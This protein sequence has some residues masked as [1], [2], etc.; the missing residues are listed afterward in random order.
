MGGMERR[1]LAI[2]LIALLMLG[3]G[4]TAGA[5]EEAPSVMQLRVDG[6]VDPFMSDYVKSGLEDAQGAGME[7]VLI[8]ID[9]PGGLMSSMREITQEI[10]N[11]PVPVITYVYP[12][13]ARA[14]S[15]GTFILM[16]APV[17]AMA[18]G[19][20][21]GAAH[22][23]GLAG[24]VESEK[25]TNDAA[26]YLQSIAEAQGRNEEWA[27]E[28]VRE[29]SSIT[30]E[31]ALDTNVIDIIAQDI[32][33]LL[34]QTDGM[35]VTVGGG[36]TVTLDTSGAT[37]V[38]NDM[39]GFIGFLHALLNPDVAFI[40]F[41]LGL[42]LIIL[43]IFA[44]G[45]LAGTLGGIMFILA[46]V[47]FGMLPVQLIGIA[48]LIVSV[49][50]FIVELKHPGVGGPAIVGAIA[51]IAG[52]LLLFDPSVPNAQV[53][54]FIVA[55]MAVL[56]G[57]FFTFVIGAAIQMRRRPSAMKQ[58]PLVGSIAKVKRALEPEGVVIVNAEEWTA[59]SERPI[60]AGQKVRVRSVDGLTLE[61]EPV[62]EATQQEGSKT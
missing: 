14:A 36:E 4:S 45:G 46:I 44:P 1:S 18:P 49:I 15:A 55:L 30:A 37:I 52:G 59:V 35:Q 8:T 19:T 60:A 9:T 58:A 51:L 54:P 26:A 57:L 38:E 12:A 61:V 10:L 47:S 6:V 22:P 24:A 56:A 25:A 7:A 20:N 29:S 3:F 23:V 33:D 13:G 31:E 40:F 50:A 21:V 32:P 53:S 5:Q 11:S 34:G 42:G 27:E 28:A 16:S 62:A 43:E 39:G 2:G 41:W 48:L 17:A